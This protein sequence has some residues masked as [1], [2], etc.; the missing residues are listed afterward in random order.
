LNRQTNGNDKALSA[1][2]YDSSVTVVEAYFAVFVPGGQDEVTQSQIH[3]GI[4]GKFW[5]L[6]KLI[7]LH[8]VRPH[9]QSLATLVR[10]VEGLEVRTQA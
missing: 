6:V 5:K 8:H 10:L 3:G 4:T 7:Q 1:L 9:T 2:G